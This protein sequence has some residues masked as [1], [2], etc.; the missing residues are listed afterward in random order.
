MRAAQA[1][2]VS[3]NHHR[4][5]SAFAEE[6][7]RGIGLGAV[8]LAAGTAGGV[9]LVAQLWWGSSADAVVVVPALYA[10]AVVGAAIC[11]FLLTVRARI[12]DD[13]V[14]RWVAAGFATA[15]AALFGQ[16]L[17]LFGPTDAPFSST[18]SGAAALYLLWHTALPVLVVAAVLVP[19]RGLLRRLA[20]SGFVLAVVVISWAPAWLRLP[21]LVDEAGAFTSQ[22]RTIVLTLVAL[23]VV[24]ALV[25]TVHCGRHPSRVQAWTTVVLV[26]SCLDLILASGADR[27]FSALWWSSA[28][29]RATTF[30]IPAV[31]LLVDAG[32]SLRLLHLHEQSLAERL[33][34]E[35]ERATSSVEVAAPDSGAHARIRAALEPGAIRC[36]YQPIYSLVTGDLAAVEALARFSLTPVRPPDR[37]FAE[38]HTVGLGVELE[39]AAVEAALRGADELPFEVP[40]TLNVSPSVLLRPELLD[41]VASAPEQLLVVE[42]TEHAAVE[43]YQRLCDAISALRERG[44]R[45]AIDDAG[46]GFA[47][48][49]HI[50]RL[51]PDVI[52]LDMTLTRDIHL[53]PVRRSL[54]ASLVSFAEQIGALLVAEGVEQSEEL[55]TWQELG[56]HAAQGYLLGRPGGLPVGASC[57]AVPRQ[58]ERAEVSSEM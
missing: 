38:A 49:R 20:T 10:V 57:D 39:L 21:E 56:A 11:V 58:V 41:L 5:P 42:V 2:A 9:Y 27:F 37:W 15:G 53:D 12:I 33:Q 3:G 44:V 1:A 30:A 14:A 46:A 19:G 35:L 51:V 45:L 26:L 28:S 43:D 6:A 36:Q 48:M 16:A 17:V 25:W 34:L 32:R 4:T 54:A 31:G 7:H 55:T 50:V 47:S 24:A 52:K 40:L 29:A 22:Y 13:P 8:L 18:P 23:T